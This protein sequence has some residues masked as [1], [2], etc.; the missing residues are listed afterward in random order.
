M[1]LSL[2]VTGDLA[3]WKVSGKIPVSNPACLSHLAWNGSVYLFA[4]AEVTGKGP[5]SHWQPVLLTS[6]DL[7]T[8]KRAQL[9]LEMS[10]LSVNDIQS[11]RA[12][13]AAF[14][15]NKWGPSNW[16]SSDGSSWEPCAGLSGD[17]TAMANIDGQFVA[18]G[19]SGTGAMVWTSVNG[20]STWVARPI[21]DTSPL[22]AMVVTSNGI[23]AVASRDDWANSKGMT[24]EASVWASQDGTSW[25]RNASTGL[26]RSVI[27]YIASVP[28]GLIATGTNSNL[29]PAVWTS[30]DGSTWLSDQ[31]EAPLAGEV[32]LVS[33]G[34]IAVLDLVGT[35]AVCTEIATR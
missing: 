18:I 1:S 21:D 24:G 6:K 4:G 3:K 30:I 13:F 7:M 25:H 5:S 23:I 8:W 12:G 29:Q 35:L 16:C 15:S 34:K 17:V 10:W 22:G 27:S 33:N 2:Q 11:G 9:P 31:P 28:G 32:P 26:G 20:G 14:G 19:S